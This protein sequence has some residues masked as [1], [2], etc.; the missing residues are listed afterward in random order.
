MIRHITLTLLLTALVFLPLSTMAADQERAVENVFIILSSDS[1]QTQGMAM[2]LANTMIDEGATVDVLLCDA[3]GDMALAQDDGGP[4]LSPREVTPGKL[5][6]TL[7]D[8]GAS[9][10]V[11][12][13]YLPNSEYTEADLAEGVSVAKPPEMTA[14]MRDPEVRVFTF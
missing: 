5:L 11:C 3:A 12:A 8:K 1:P 4:K 14:L 13:L 10:S 7:M 9:V 2:V 6:G